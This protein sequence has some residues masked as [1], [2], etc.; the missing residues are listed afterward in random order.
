LFPG[1]YVFIGGIAVQQF[2]IL[3]FTFFTIRFHRT[4]LQQVK[5]GVEGASSALPLLYAIYAVLILII[6]CS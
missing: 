5:K 6:V 2:F 4:L 3:V 1:I